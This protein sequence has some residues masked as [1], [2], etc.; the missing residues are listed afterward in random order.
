MDTEKEGLT[1]ER[2][3]RQPETAELRLAVKRGP[4]RLRKIGRLKQPGHGK[5]RGPE[6]SKED[7][8]PQPAPKSRP[9]RPRKKSRPNSGD[10]VA[11]VDGKEQAVH[12]PGGAAT[13]SEE[14]AFQGLGLQEVN[15][16]G[17]GCQL[18]PPPIG[19]VFGSSRPNI[20]SRKGLSGS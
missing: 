6:R 5:Q 15:N 14:R 17:K 20:L 13:D 8:G 10:G 16:R 3:S 11:K 19:G 1:Q 12:D 2:S 7:E 4:G 18:N 9:G